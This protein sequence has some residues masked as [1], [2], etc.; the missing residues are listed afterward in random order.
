V[1]AERLDL[2]IETVLVGGLLVSAASLLAGLLL[3]SSAALRW[4]MM[5]LMATP[6]ARVLVVLAA[7]VAQRDWLFAAVSFWITA[8]LLSSFVVSLGL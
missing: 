3:D 5:L 6:A 8:V 2:T 7:F 1:K 4:G